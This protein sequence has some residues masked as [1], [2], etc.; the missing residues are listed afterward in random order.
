MEW[1]TEGVALIFIGFIVAGVTFI[2]TKNNVSEFIYISSAAVLIV[3]AVV[4]L[5][6]GFKV[7]FLPYKLCPFIFILSV[8]L[9]LVGR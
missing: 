4:S 3:L 8:V 7:N 5:F 1:I 2:G 9:I 6:T